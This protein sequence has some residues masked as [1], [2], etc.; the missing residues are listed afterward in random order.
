MIAV[1][2]R[3]L[4]TIGVTATVVFAVYPVSAGESSGADVGIGAADTKFQDELGFRRDFGLNTDPEFV[5]Q[6]MT[7]PAAYEGGYGVA[8]T[9]DELSDLQRRLEIQNQIGPLKGFAEA[10]PSFAGLWFN[11]RRGGVITVAFA[12]SAPTYR[13]VIEALAPT[14]STVEVIDVQYSWAQLEETLELV[15]RDRLSLKKEGLWIRELG[16]DPRPN[17]VEVKIEELTDA[18]VRQLHA[19][20]GDTIVV[21]QSGHP[22]YTACVNRYDCIGPPVRAGIATT[23][24]G[25]SLSFLVKVSGAPGTGWLTA[26]HPPCGPAGQVVYHN[27]IAIGTIRKSCWDPCLRAD[28]SLGGW[29]NATY[30]SYRVYFTSTSN[31][32]VRYQQ[33]EYG[34]TIGMTTCLNARRQ[35]GDWGF[36]CGVLDEINR[37][38]YGDHYF[39]DQRYAT[40]HA[41][42][43]DSGGAVNS[44]RISGTV[45]TVDA[46]G[47]Q[48]GCENLDGSPDGCEPGQADGRGIYSHVS[49]ATYE[50]GLQYGA[51]ITVCRV[52][53]PCP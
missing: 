16:I 32:Q 51:T 46:Y 3:R 9:P 41:Y 15:E 28:A 25:C 38:D 17:R 8:L 29:L 22:T 4:V 33:G 24:N 20:F 10:Q 39:L 34:D 48:S 36:R 35:P 47:V 5:A 23:S 12:G 21:E 11:Q 18:A 42:N 19:R 26:S 7:N 14:G 27:G 52:A 44:P 45:W 13:E 40:Y 49:W 30:A 2:I 50:L 37:V 31:T 43:G 1:T 53:S 6:L